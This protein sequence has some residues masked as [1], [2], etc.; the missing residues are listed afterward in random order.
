MHAPY[1]DGLHKL[2]RTLGMSHGQASVWRHGK[3][4]P[5]RAVQ[6]IMRLVEIHGWEALLSGELAQTT[7]KLAQ[8]SPQVP[9]PKRTRKRKTK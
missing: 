6:F 2:V 3:A 1:G 8:D 4:K 9:K 7:N 5:S